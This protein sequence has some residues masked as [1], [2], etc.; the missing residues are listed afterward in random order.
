MDFQEEL[1]ENVEK[2]SGFLFLPSYYEALHA[3]PAADRHAILDAMIFYA[4]EDR[5]PKM[6]PARMAVFTVVRANI[7]AS[8]ERYR[9]MSANGKKGGRPK[10]KASFEELAWKPGESFDEVCKKRGYHFPD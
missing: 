2:K 6:N 10:K 9:K 3:L 7:D 4:F 1:S 5:L 8:R